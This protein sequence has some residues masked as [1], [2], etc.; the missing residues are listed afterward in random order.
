MTDQYRALS[1][2]AQN[3]NAFLSETTVRGRRWS[4]DSL[5]QHVEPPSPEFISR[6]GTSR[7]GDLKALMASWRYQLLACVVSALSFAGLAFVAI[8][9]NNRPLSEWPSSSVSINAV[10]AA[11]ATIMRAT[12]LV[13]IAYTVGQAK[14]SWF[15]MTGEAADSKETRD[16]PLGELEAIDDVSR[17][18]GGGIF[19][20]FKHPLPTNLVTQ[21][22]ILTILA[23]GLGFF[24][25]QIISVETRHFRDPVLKAHIPWAQNVTSFDEASWTAAFYNGFFSDTIE[26]LP[27]DCQTGNCTWDDVVPSIAVQGE[28]VDITEDMADKEWILCDDIESCN[29]TS[30]TTDDPIVYLEY[31]LPPNTTWP[32]FTEPEGPVRIHGKRAAMTFVDMNLFPSD[33]V[34]AFRTGGPE[35]TSSDFYRIEVV[36]IPLTFNTE[37]TIAKTGSPTLSQ[38]TFRYGIQ[39]YLPNVSSG[40]LTQ[41]TTEGPE[42]YKT[43]IPDPKNPG[44]VEAHFLDQVPGFNMQNRTFC[45]W[46][47][48]KELFMH[49]YLPADIELDLWTDSYGDLGQR[50]SPF[51]RRWMDTKDDRDGWVSRFAKSLTNSIRLHSQVSKEDDVHTGSVIV[52]EAYIRVSWWWM[53]PPGA[54]ILLSLTLFFMSLLRIA[55]RHE[56]EGGTGAWFHGSLLLLLSRVDGKIW[57]KARGAY[58]SSDHLLK[59]V[60]KQKVRLVRDDKD[61][62]LL[63]VTQDRLA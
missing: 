20:L 24:S 57:Q 55:L 52:T 46:I 13:P 49:D 17:G 19:W 39:A 35:R 30:G 8:R 6:T 38:C 31:G 56:K 60:G 40:K 53:I 25:Q 23:G 16:R 11:L 9:F 51:I 43:R 4:N 59:A 1:P 61:D 3:P 2:I 12:I 7:T 14:W 42:A 27:A 22:A 21:G 26:D 28:C 45:I 62:G 58:G 5:G 10:V 33:P 32:M 50:G 48:Y 36:E 41:V 34:D 47:Q 37:K 44:R 54:L 18:P 63:F 29:Y 15:V